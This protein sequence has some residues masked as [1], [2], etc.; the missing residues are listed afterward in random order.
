MAKGAAYNKSPHPMVVD[1]VARWCSGLTY[2][3]VKAEIGGSNPLRVAISFSVKSGVRT[4]PCEPFFVVRERVLPAKEFVPRKL[5]A[6]CNAVL[7]YRQSR[8]PFLSS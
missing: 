2:C 1:C 6:L 3:P 4:A 7:L 8:R 5:R